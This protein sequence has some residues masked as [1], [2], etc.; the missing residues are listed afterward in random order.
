MKGANC[1]ISVDGYGSRY[2]VVERIQHGMNVVANEG[3]SRVGRAFYPVKR[4]SGSF[5]LVVV[6]SSNEEMMSFAGWLAT[7]AVTASDGSNRYGPMRVQVPDAGF[8]KVAI[9]KSGINFGDTYDEVVWKL[10]LGFEGA[11][12]TLDLDSALVSSFSFPETV[13]EIG[14]YFYP[15]GTPLDDPSPDPPPWYLYRPGGV[16]GYDLPGPASPAPTSPGETP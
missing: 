14:R 1:A 8:D 3:S 6:F 11:R 4:T 15:S 2:C 16:P 7:Y 5:G 12:G 13:D 10:N 9:I